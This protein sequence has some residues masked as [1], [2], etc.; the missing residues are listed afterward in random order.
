MTGTEIGGNWGNDD[1]AW[2][3]FSNLSATD[4]TIMVNGSAGVVSWDGSLLFAG[5]VKETITIPAGETWVDPLKFDKVL[6]HMNRLWFADSINLAVYYLPIQSKGGA[7]ADGTLFLLPLNAIFKRGG[8]IVSICTWSID[9]GVGLDDAIAIFTSN[10]EVA[11]YSGVN[12]EGEEFRLVGLFHFDAPMSKNSVLNFGGDLYVMIS[13]GFV[14][15]TTMIRAETEQLGKSD[16]T[17]M[18]EFEEIARYHRTEGGWQVILNHH[19]NH[20]ICNMPIGGG[21]YQ[22]MVRKMPGQ[23]WAK[24]RDIPSRCWGWIDNRAYFGSDDGGIYQGGVDY[25][26]DNG[27]AIEADVRF[28]WSGFKSVTSKSFKMV[29]LYTLTDGIVRPFIDVETDYDPQLPTNQPDTSLGGT[30]AVWNTAT[31]D[32]DYWDTQIAPQQ[33]WQGVTGLGR[34]GA[35]RVRVSIKD[36]SFAITGLDVVYELG[37]IM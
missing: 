27:A 18:K 23:V 12:P 35:P 33:N 26:S 20:A 24:W 14:P 32:A 8:H 31:W 7:G 34:V 29:R 37:S 6:S 22:Q 15:M 10:G 2:T 17:V 28:A 13:S 19:T 16:L 4:Y 36:C 5:F 1:W 21:K 11:I 3:S 30:G 25:F 9:G